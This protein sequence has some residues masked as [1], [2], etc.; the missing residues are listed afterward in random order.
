MSGGRRL[1]SRWIAAGILA[2][3]VVLA[4]GGEVFAEAG[5][6]ARVEGGV[7]FTFEGRNS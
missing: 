4:A 7:L 3:L 5:P 1:H 2:G 6:P